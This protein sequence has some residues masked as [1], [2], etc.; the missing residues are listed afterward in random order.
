MGDN[1]C[2]STGDVQ[3]IFMPLILEDPLTW[4]A[5]CQSSENHS[6]H[7]ILVELPIVHWPSM[8]RVNET[9]N[10]RP[11]SRADLQDSCRIAAAMPCHSLTLAK[12]GQVQHDRSD[13]AGYPSRSSVWQ[14]RC[15]GTRLIRLDQS[16][17]SAPHVSCPDGLDKSHSEHHR[18]IRRKHIT[19]VSSPQISKLLLRSRRPPLRHRVPPRFRSSRFLDSS[20]SMPSLSSISAAIM[21]KFSNFRLAHSLKNSKRKRRATISE[22]YDAY[23]FVSTP[24][25]NDFASFVAHSSRL[26]PTD[27]GPTASCSSS[28]I[29][30]TTSTISSTTSLPDSSSSLISS[31]TSVLSNTTSAL[32]CSS[33]TSVATPSGTGCGDADISCG[34]LRC[35]ASSLGSPNKPRPRHLVSVRSRTSCF[36]QAYASDRA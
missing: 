30:S 23:I 24:S 28:A 31:A 5:T 15:L 26:H 16:R 25:S 20:A 12:Q 4:K 1:S 9:I 13:D 32:T 35:A 19:N 11:N 2:I 27:S 22:G 10:L 14:H 29:S 33:T 17:S 3:Y 6:I 8:S 36:M 7:Q 34:P 18:I 21:Q